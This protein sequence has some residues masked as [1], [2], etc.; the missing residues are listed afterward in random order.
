MVTQWLKQEIQ[1]ER[2]PGLAARQRECGRFVSKGRSVCDMM[3]LA[4][5]G[6]L[7]LQGV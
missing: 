5:E 3:T 1:Q 6:H 7:W 2:D 4:F